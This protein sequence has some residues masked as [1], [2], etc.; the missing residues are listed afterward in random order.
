MEE[1]EGAE[2]R[3][4]GD[5]FETLV[6]LSDVGAADGLSGWLSDHFSFDEVGVRQGSR[7]VLL[8]IKSGIDH[9]GS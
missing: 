7:E 8:E 9:S 1:V 4:E 3:M 5:Y 6:F 2:I